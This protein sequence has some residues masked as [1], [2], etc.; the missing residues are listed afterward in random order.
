MENDPTL[1]LTLSPSSDNL[2]PKGL[3]QVVSS[4]LAKLS[5]IVDLTRIVLTEH[6]FTDSRAQVG[7]SLAST[8]GDDGKG[9]T[10]SRW[11]DDSRILIGRGGVM[12]GLGNIP[13]AFGVFDRWATTEGDIMAEKVLADLDSGEN[14]PWL[15]DISSSEDAMST[16]NRSERS[17][18]AV[19]L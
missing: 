1:I 5:I 18:L 12:N 3:L 17:V 11:K 8:K 4:L 13:A 9:L 6:F 19:G 7:H 2:R 15:Q 16:K 14:R 10:V